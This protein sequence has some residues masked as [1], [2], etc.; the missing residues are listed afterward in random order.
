MDAWQALP[1]WA[2]QGALPEAV[3]MAQREQRLRHHAGGLASSLIQH[4]LGEMPDL[5][6]QLSRVTSRVD[7]VVGERDVKFVA[8]GHELAAVMP[9]AKLTLVPAVGHNLLLECPGL[10]A[11][12]L[13]QGNAP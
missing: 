9:T 12:L 1:L 2:S 13:L 11:G 10:V 5:L 3:K 4:G 8:L 6:A 7:V